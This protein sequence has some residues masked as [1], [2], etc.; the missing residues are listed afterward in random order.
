MAGQPP[1]AQN[2]F[3]A[4]CAVSLVQGHT[5]KGVYIKHSM[6]KEYMKEA[7]KAFGN[8]G[9]SHCSKPDYLTTVTKAHS[10]CES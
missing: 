9:I 4:C 2:Y 1:E 6:L 7:L 5:I 3:L 8:R 10:D